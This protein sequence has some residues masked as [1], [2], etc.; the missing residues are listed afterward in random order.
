MKLEKVGLTLNLSSE[1]LMHMPKLELIYLKYANDL[2][3][4]HVWMSLEKSSAQR[5]S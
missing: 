3:S 1:W 5:V 2:A 4:G